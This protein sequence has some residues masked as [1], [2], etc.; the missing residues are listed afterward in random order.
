MSADIRLA[1]SAPRPMR[2]R[3][4]GWWLFAEGRL[5]SMAAYIWTVL[6]TAVGTPALYLLAFGTGLGAVVGQSRPE[7]VDG[8]PYLVY[9]APA[10]LLSTSMMTA[11]E[12]ATF[13]VFGGF[14]WNPV[15]FAAAATPISPAQIALGFLAANLARC[16]LGAVAFVGIMALAGAAPSPWAPLILLVDVLLVAAVAGPIMAFVASQ[17]DDRGQL[18]L[19]QRFVITPLML[20]SGT[21]FPLETLPAA[22]QWIGWASP[23]WHAVELGRACTYGHA[24]APGMLAL[25]LGYLALLAVAGLALAALL[26]RRRLVS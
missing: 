4:L 6:I 9:L 3:L 5:R 21:Y 2:V 19:I 8:V 17:R 22:L 26:F 14:K 10:L 1:P 18:S 7:G 13:S 15:S 12:E 16:L 23:L 25:H 11:A 20:F 24:V